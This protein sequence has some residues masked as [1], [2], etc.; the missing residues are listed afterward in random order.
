MCSW[1][2]EARGLLV[3][4]S[5]WMYTKGGVSTTWIGDWIYSPAGVMYAPWKWEPCASALPS[6][7]ICLRRH[8]C[9]G[10][11]V[12]ER[13]ACLGSRP[14]VCVCSPLGCRLDL[15]CMYAILYFTY[16]GPLLFR[17]W[18]ERAPELDLQA[19]VMCSRFTLKS[20]LVGSTSSLRPDNNPE[21]RMT[22]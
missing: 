17:I 12:G 3:V 20:G 18:A 5:R 1:K 21:V 6:Q 9:G 22:T 2:H 4:C 13:R 15:S 7:W 19:R 16:L 8:M 14:V 10:V 11:V